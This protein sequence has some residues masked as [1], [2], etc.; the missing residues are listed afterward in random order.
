MMLIWCCHLSAIFKKSMMGLI[1]RQ[2]DFNVSR[3]QLSLLHANMN[4]V[5]WI[6]GNEEELEDNDV[7]MYLNF[8]SMFCK[9]LLYRLSIQCHVT[10]YCCCFLCVSCTRLLIKS[11]LKAFWLIALFF[12]SWLNICYQFHPQAFKGLFLF[13]SC[14]ITIPPPIHTSLLQLL[15]FNVMGELEPISIVRDFFWK[16]TSKLLTDSL[17]THSTG[18]LHQ[19]NYYYFSTR[20]NKG[21]LASDFLM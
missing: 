9:P 11:S 13:Y 8:W 16:K 3:L 7:V 2:P 10:C 18:L 20:K 4:Y 14:E 15:P 1:K 17:F 5:H 19:Q 21:E 12:F 6:G